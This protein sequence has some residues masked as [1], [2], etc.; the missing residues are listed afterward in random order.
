MTLL[1]L[2]SMSGCLAIALAMT[3]AAGCSGPSVLARQAQ[4]LPSFNAGQSAF[5]GTL[6]TADLDAAT[7][8]RVTSRPL[9]PVC[10]ASRSAPAGGAA[11]GAPAGMAPQLDSALANEVS[12]VLEAAT[13]AEL[14]ER[15]RLRARPGGASIPEPRPGQIRSVSASCLPRPGVAI[16]GTVTHFEL[17]YA[18]VDT[19]GGDQEVVWLG[20]SPSS[21]EIGAMRVRVSPKASPPPVNLFALSSVK[22]YGVPP[23]PPIVHRDGDRAFQVFFAPPD[24][25]SGFYAI[26]PHRPED[27]PD[28]VLFGRFAVR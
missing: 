18:A 17:V 25:R 6:L 7:W 5:P 11:G 4:A 21:G 19:L 9:S 24:A 22:Q 16:N 10:D 26:A 13:N 1:S 3:G 27:G 12:R 2:T 28:A 14:T 15:D 23:G 20:Y 8:A